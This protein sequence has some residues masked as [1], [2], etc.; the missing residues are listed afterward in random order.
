MSP[1]PWS[2]LELR[3]FIRGQNRMVR[4]ETRILVSVIQGQELALTPLPTHLDMNQ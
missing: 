2:E 3:V 1:G 4:G